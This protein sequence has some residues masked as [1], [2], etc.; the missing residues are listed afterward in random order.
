M[1]SSIPPQPVKSTA[2]SSAWRR[3]AGRASEPV[4]F[5]STTLP[6]QLGAAAARVATPGP[7]KE[8]G[9]LS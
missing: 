9:D 2:Q 5:G 1:S 3:P 6:S 7:P 4:T 8:K